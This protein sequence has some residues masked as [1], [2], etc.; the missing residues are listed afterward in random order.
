MTLMGGDRVD[1]PR[2][3]RRRIIVGNAIGYVGML[4]AVLIYLREAPTH[5][6]IYGLVGAAVGVG[7]GLAYRSLWTLRRLQRVTRHENS[8]G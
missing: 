8:P 2:Q 4:S 5:P 1:T 6:F 7:T 3:L